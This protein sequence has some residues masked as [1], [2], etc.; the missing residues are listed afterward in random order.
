VLLGGGVITPG[1][2]TGTASARMTSPHV[3]ERAC[4]TRAVIAYRWSNV[5]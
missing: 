1:D 4:T 2:G 5:N 3:T